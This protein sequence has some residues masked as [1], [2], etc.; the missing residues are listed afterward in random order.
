MPSDSVGTSRG[1]NPGGNSCGN[2]RETTGGLTSPRGIA[3]YPAAAHSNFKNH[4]VSRGLPREPTRVPAGARVG[5]RGSPWEPLGACGDSHG[6]PA[7]QYILERKTRRLEY[8]IE[9]RNYLY[10]F[11][12]R[13]VVHTSMHVSLLSSPLAVVPWK[14]EKQT[15]TMLFFGCR[16]TDVLYER[17]RGTSS[18]P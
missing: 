15:S 16:Q 18:V 4:M 1:E 8:R 12:Y 5:T 9:M 3:W 11:R 10:S 2:S 14:Q 17:Q 6:T 7:K 13:A